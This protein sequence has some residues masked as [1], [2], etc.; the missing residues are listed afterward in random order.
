MSAGVPFPFAIF[1]CALM[2]SSSGS[3]LSVCF[4]VLVVVVTVVGLTGRAGG[5]GLSALLVAP[6]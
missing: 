4:R 3:L 1:L 6:E 2:Y 5:G